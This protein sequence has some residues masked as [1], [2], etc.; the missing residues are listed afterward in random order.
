MLQLHHHIRSAVFARPN[1]TVAVT[2][3][4][5]VGAGFLAVRAA[6]TS[7]A[8]AL[9]NSNDAAQRSE[10]EDEGQLVR[11]G[12]RLHAE[13][14]EFKV[15]GDRA[16]FISQDGG[17][18]YGGLENQ[19]LER[20]VLKISDNPTQLTW[21]VTGDVTEYRGTNYL[22]V[23]HA[24]IKNRNSAVPTGQAAEAASTTP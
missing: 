24:V 17:Q 15:R 4:F 1:R 6:S 11:E 13:L 19:N 10:E 14:G 9:E 2:L 22:L 18:H 20:I 8:Y 12:V 3:L 7:V 5:L 16:I 21:E 23:T